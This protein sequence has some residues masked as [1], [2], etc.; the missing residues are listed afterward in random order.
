MIFHKGVRGF[1]VL[2]TS[3]FIWL[4]LAFLLPMIER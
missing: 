1:S 3:F 4:N 2:L